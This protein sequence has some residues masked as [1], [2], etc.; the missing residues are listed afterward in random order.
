MTRFFGKVGVETAGAYVDG[1]WTVDIEERDFFGDVP[2]ETSS[3]EPSE[4]VNAD[5]RLQNRIDIH[6]DVSSAHI[7][8]IKYVSV[9]G[10]NWEVI[11]ARVRRP[12]IEL[13]LGGI[14]NGK[15]A[16]DPPGSP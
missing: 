16:N 13:S 2:D 3:S 14:Y 4:K 12:R 15:T 8:K 10:E 7:T 5:Y 1:V 11:S 9:Y 6:A